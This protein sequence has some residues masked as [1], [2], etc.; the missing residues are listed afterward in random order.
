MLLSDTDIKQALE[1]KKIV[2]DP[3][4]DLNVALSAC[5]IDLRL[6]FEFEVFL[7]TR[8][9][10]FDIRKPGPDPITK[11]MVLKKKEPFILQP[12]QFVLG[13]TLEW[14]ELPDDIAGRLEGRSSLGRLGIIVHSTAALIHPG[15]KGRIVLELSNL[16]PMAVTLYPEMRVCALAFEKL[17]QPAAVP[18]SKQKGAKYFGQKGVGENKISEEI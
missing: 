12:G 9:M 6:N 1:T 16:S 3:L 2:I 5:A 14:I 13:S 17:T 4:P 11:K 18:Y 8:S 7:Q 15:I 10:Y